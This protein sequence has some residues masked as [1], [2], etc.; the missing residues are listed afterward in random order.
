MV[1]GLAL[2]VARDLLCAL[3]RADAFMTGL[4]PIPAALPS[5]GAATLIQR[6]AA[7]RTTRALPRYNPAI[8]LK[9]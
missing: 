1:A 8:C 3:A 2:A 7:G 4:L 6:A 9:Q 5:A